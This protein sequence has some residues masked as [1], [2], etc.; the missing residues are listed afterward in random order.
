MSEK[1]L[2]DGNISSELAYEISYNEESKSLRLELKHDGKGS[3]S[4]M[5]HELKAEYLLDKLAEAIPGEV[6]DKVLALL[7]AA[8]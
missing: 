1:E 8:L 6:D 2:L 7:K 5:Y 3:S 4:G